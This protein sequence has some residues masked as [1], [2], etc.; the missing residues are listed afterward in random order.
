MLVLLGTGVVANVILPKN[1]GFS[2]GWVVITFGWGLAVMSGVYVS[3]KSGAHINPAVT[4]GLYLNGPDK[5][6]QF[7][8]GITSSFSNMLLYWLAQMIGAIIGAVLCWL[9]YK[10]HFDEDADPAT[11]LGVFSTGPAMTMSG[12]HLGCCTPTPGRIC[13]DR[14]SSAM[15]PTRASR[16]RTLAGEPIGCGSE[17]SRVTSANARSAEKTV[18]DAL[19]GTDSG[20]RESLNASQEPSISATSSAR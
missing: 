1:K 15:R 10:K 13:G 18:A 5:A 16:T 3:F 20:T 6:D 11:K 14:P 12:I 8:K 4:L 7:A 17:A 19:A 2:S 9:A